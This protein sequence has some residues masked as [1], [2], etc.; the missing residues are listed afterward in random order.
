MNRLPA[1]ERASKVQQLRELAQQLRDL[2]TSAGGAGHEDSILGFAGQADSY[3]DRI[4][5]AA[6]PE[7]AGTLVTEVARKEAQWRQLLELL[8]VATLC[9]NPDGVQADSAVVEALVQE[10]EQK[11]RQTAAQLRSVAD[12][13]TSAVFGAIGAVATE[14]E[15]GLADFLSAE[16]VEAKMEVYARVEECRARWLAQMEDLHATVADGSESQAP[17]E[18]PDATDPV[19]EYVD[20]F[21]EDVSCRPMREAA[22][23]GGN[24]CVMP[25]EA[26][27]SRE[28]SS[29]YYNFFSSASCTLVASPASSAD[30]GVASSPP[31]STDAPVASISTPHALKEVPALLTE[32]ANVSQKEAREHLKTYLNDKDEG[33]LATLRTVVGKVKEDDRFEGVHED[34]SKLLEQMELAAGAITPEALVQ[35]FSDNLAGAE[36]KLKAT[37]EPMRKAQWGGFYAKKAAFSVQKY[38]LY[39]AKG[40]MPKLKDEHSELLECA[41]VCVDLA[42]FLRKEA[43]N[44]ILDSVTGLVTQTMPASNQ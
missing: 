7:A 44:A 11:L 42:E 16:T 10:A 23:I 27:P 32:G 38:D 33:L 13:G 19:C 34:A 28:S 43:Q 30:C 24:G 5:D 15:V 41:K 35:E 2:S 6:S 36:D 21:P 37:V 17:T 25:S 22:P 1:D 3:A 39:V 14:A 9:E 26:M 40:K 18:A 4:R 12:G 31:V 20:D 29:G 8:N